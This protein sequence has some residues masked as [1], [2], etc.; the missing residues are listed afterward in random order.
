MRC[1]CA[2]RRFEALTES[3][4]RR[5]IEE[6]FFGFVAARAGR[7]SR[8]HFAQNDNSQVGG[9][10]VTKSRSLA[11]KNGARDDSGEDA[12]KPFETPFGKLRAGRASRR[13]E[14]PQGP[15]NAA[16][17]L[18]YKT[19]GAKA[20]GKAEMPMSELKLR[21]PNKESAGAHDC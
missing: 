3:G 1:D 5:K 21:P 7:K 16:G 20:P 12:R 6:G 13:Y 4:V 10:E 11:P 9:Q 2:R 18:G 15:A 14:K 19:S 8:D 17:A